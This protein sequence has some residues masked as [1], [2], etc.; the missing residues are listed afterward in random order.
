MKTKFFS[1]LSYIFL[2]MYD[3]PSDISK[4]KNN[5]HRRFEPSTTPKEKP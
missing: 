5:R 3:M 2:S 4:S 1:L